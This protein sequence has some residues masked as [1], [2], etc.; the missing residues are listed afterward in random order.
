MPPSGATGSSVGYLVRSGRRVHLPS[1]QIIHMTIGILLRMLMSNRS[2]A[3][4][5]DNNVN[6][7]SLS[8]GNGNNEDDDKE[9]ADGCR[10]KRGRGK[11]V[12]PLIFILGY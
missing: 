2:G 7:G 12:V 4:A 9:G 6:N 1:C 10:G 8:Y 5:A 3:V 11:A